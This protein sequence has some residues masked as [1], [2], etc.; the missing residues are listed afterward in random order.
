MPWCEFVAFQRSYQSTNFQIFPISFN[1]LLATSTT[2]YFDISGTQMI[3]NGHV[4]IH[5][6][7]SALRPDKILWKHPARTASAM[8]TLEFALPLGLLR[9]AVLVE[10]PCL[11]VEHSKLFL[12][13][14]PSTSAV[15]AEKA[16]ELE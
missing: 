1:I 9:F 16:P 13:A 14:G 10:T 8:T 4:A 2:Y 11:G 7:N 12:K 5:D 3:T 15:M 6:G